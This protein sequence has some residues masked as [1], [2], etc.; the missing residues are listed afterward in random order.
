[1]QRIRP[2]VERLEAEIGIEHALASKKLYTDGVEV[3]YDYAGGAEAGDLVVVRTQQ[4]PFREVI[5]DYLKRIGYAHDGWASSIA[6]PLYGRTQ[7]F[8]DPTVGFGQPVVAHGGARVEDL[9]ERFQAGDT[10]AE[11]VDDFGV[12]IEE[13]EDVIRVATRLAA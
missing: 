3:L 6:L 9:I 4:R 10:V 8:V 11:L 2:A 13:V 12:P 5:R 1:M 7:V